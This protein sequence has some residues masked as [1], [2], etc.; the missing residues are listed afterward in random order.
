MTLSPRDL[1]AIVARAQQA[2]CAVEG[3][4]R[5][6][7]KRDWCSMHY[8][9]WRLHGDPEHT[10]TRPRTVLGRE[11]GQD[12]RFWSKVAVGHPLGCWQWTGWTNRLGYGITRY[13]GR[14]QRVHRV[15]FQLLRGSLPER[16]DHGKRLVIDHLCRNRSCVNPDH[17]EPVTDGENI[18]RGEGLS[19]KRA[20]QQRCRRGHLL[21]GDNLIVRRSGRRCRTCATGRRE[22]GR[23]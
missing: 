6:R 13:D 1:D 8:T 4:A 7:R 12:D 20:R 18:R 16:D 10:K 2:Q 23:R 21:A 19:A 11:A 22:Q 9:R 3:C 14:E 15:A 17:L 5:S